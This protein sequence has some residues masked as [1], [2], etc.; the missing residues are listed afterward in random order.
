MAL[1]TGGLRCASGV[2]ASQG[3]DESP[4]NH[5]GLSAGGRER[6]ALAAAC[7]PR[8]AQSHDHIKKGTLEPLPYQ[9]ASLKV[10]DRVQAS[11]PSR[12]VVVR[13]ERP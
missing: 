9:G 6:D 12:T 11:C 10:P 5:L 8:Y 4:G 13:L 7:G 3:I 1:P 2:G